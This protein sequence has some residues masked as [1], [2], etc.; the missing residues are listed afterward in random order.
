[1]GLRIFVDKLLDLAESIPVAGGFHVDI[2]NNQVQYMRDQQIEA[3]PLPALFVEVLFSSGGHDADVLTT[4]EVQVRAHIVMEKMNMEGKFARNTEIYDMR[5]LVLQYF[6]KYHESVNGL[7]Y[8]FTPLQYTGEQ[9]QYDHDNLYEYVL[10]F[11]TM[12]SQNLG[13]YQTTKQTQGTITAII[14]NPDKV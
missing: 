1:M 9:P 8:E 10:E 3:I 14:I 6:S 12:F 11:S 7:S 13:T 2:W 5:D 4:R